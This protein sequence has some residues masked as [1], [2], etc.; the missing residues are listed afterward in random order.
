MARRFPLCPGRPVALFSEDH[1]AFLNL[2]VADVIADLATAI[3]F[4]HSKNASARVILTF[5]PVPLV[6]TMDDRSVLVST[7]VSKSVLR[8]AAEEIAAQ[9]DFVAYF[10]SYE[11]ITGNYNRGGY[12]AEDLRSVTEAGVSHVMRLFMKHYADNT[13]K[14]ITTP[15]DAEQERQSVEAHIH[16]MQQVAAVICDE[17]ALGRC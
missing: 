17:E 1:Y 5:S 10:P 9:R 8:V 3:S 13:E 16:A 15:T 6:A 4:L 2:R 14:Q 11:V 7:T 12:F